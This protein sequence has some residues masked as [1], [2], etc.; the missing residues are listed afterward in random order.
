MKKKEKR[1]PQTLLSWRLAEQV[2]EER[3]CMENMPVLYVRGVYP[4]L[5]REDVPDEGTF[6]ATSEAVQRFND[7]Y[8]QA[9]EAFV[10]RGSDMAGP[11]IMAAY[12][13]MGDEAAHRFLRRE[14]RCIM[15]AEMISKETLD[16]AS[17]NR[18]ASSWEKEEGACLL[19]VKIQKSFGLRRKSHGDIH[20]VCEHRWQF[21]WGILL[22]C[23][24]KY[25]KITKNY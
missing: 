21:P 12:T 19:R 13:A 25:K 1:I 20:T 5:V 9:A 11:R 15:T 10:C 2:V 7:C 6:T 14:W 3:Y 16:G 8:Q 17:L 18:Q 4:V 23:E 24:G 22:N